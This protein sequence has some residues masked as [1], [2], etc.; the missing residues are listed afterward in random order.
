MIIIF[1][2]GGGWSVAGLVDFLVFV[3]FAFEFGVFFAELLEEFAIFVSGFLGNRDLLFFVL[4]QRC[5]GSP[6]ALL[7][8]LLNLLE[9]LLEGECADTLRACGDDVF[10]YFLGLLLIL[11]ILL[12]VLLTLDEV[13]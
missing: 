3:L 8:V 2:V 9:T 4:Y 5:V 7:F 13:E 10:D 11:V 12:F 1:L 6:H